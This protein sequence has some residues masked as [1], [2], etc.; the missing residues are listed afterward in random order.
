MSKASEFL[1]LVEKKA[2]VRWEP[3]SV[4][5]VKGIYTS[6]S[7][8]DFRIDVNPYKDKFSWMIGRASSDKFLNQGESPT[9]DKA[10]ADAIKFLKQ[11]EQRGIA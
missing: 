9:E 5:G 8:V 10:K 6:Q 11:M 4:G 3:N 7:D 1:N 2:E